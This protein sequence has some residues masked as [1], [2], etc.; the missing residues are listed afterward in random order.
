MPTSH[1]ARPVVLAVSCLILG[2]VGG[3]ALATVGDQTTLP[4]ARVDV[5]VDPPAPKTT[6]V[7]PRAAAEPPARGE[8]TV[9]VLNG[10]T[11]SGLAA[12]TAATLKGLGYTTVATGNASTKTGPSVVYFADGQRPAADQLATDLQIQTVTPLAG[13]P[14]AQT[15]GGGSELVVFIGA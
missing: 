14:V 11:Q 2:F 7:D 9:N 1:W 13:S 15:A 8:V 5:T 12:S 6:T 4:D 10:T 3:W